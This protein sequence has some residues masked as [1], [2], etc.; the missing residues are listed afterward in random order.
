M[1]RMP[2]GI[3]TVLACLGLSGCTAPDE[4]VE[5]ASRSQGFAGL[6]MNAEAF[7][8]VEPNGG[9]VFPADHGAHPAFRI[10][11]W[12]V[13]ANLRDPDGNAYGAQWTLFRQALAPEDRTSDRWQDGQVWMAHSAVTAADGHWHDERFG[14]RGGGQTGV[15]TEPAYRVWLDDWSLQSQAN[16]GG[17]PLDELVVEAA[18]EAYS[19]SLW[20]RADGPLV[21]H[22]RKGFSTKSG[23]G[24]ASWYYS[25]PFYQAEGSLEMPGQGTVPVTGTAWL[26]REWSSQPLAPDQAGWDWFSLQLDSGERVMLFQLRSGT[27]DAPYYSGTWINADGEPTALQPE[28]IRMRPLDQH[29]VAGRTLPVVWQ[30]AVPERG[31]DIRTRALNPDAWMDGT[32]PYW[33]GPV[34]V[35]GS[36]RGQGY[37]EM[38]GYPVD[39]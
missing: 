5:T 19:Y 22:G 1:N 17:D 7:A 24:Q 3:C 13:T 4:P 15:A 36:H 9:I 28:Q 31:L 11:W 8:R 30:L 25:Q 29:S 27:G 23:Q 12:Y 26:D 2:N 21:R 38:T 10:E 34:T 33:E 14:R 39:R 32:I 20:L 16:S 37:L 35:S 6:G 18:A